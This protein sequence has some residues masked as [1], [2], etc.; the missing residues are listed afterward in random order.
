MINQGRF[1]SFMSGIGI[2]AKLFNNCVSMERKS[3]P[4][5]VRMVAA[6]LKI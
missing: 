6:E 3:I 5:I 1:A 2:V 4:I